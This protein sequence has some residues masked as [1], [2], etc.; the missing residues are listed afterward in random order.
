MN[1]P[2]LGGVWGGFSIKAL[3]AHDPIRWPVKTRD[4]FERQQGFPLAQV[5]FSNYS[6]IRSS[7]GLHQSITWSFDFSAATCWQSGSENGGAA[8]LGKTDVQ[9]DS[10][11]SSRRRRVDPRLLWPDCS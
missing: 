8:H 2:F 10:T 4:V 7:T 9:Q 3:L 11:G 6:S 1:S 5:E